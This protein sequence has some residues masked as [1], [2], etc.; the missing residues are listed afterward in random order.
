MG[1]LF[2]DHGNSLIQVEAIVEQR[3]TNG[4]GFAP[5]SFPVRILSPTLTLQSLFKMLSSK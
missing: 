2:A 4:S 1:S 3:T 5:S